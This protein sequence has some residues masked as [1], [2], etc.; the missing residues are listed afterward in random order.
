MNI[1]LFYRSVLLL[2]DGENLH[3]SRVRKLRSRRP[4]D[5]G[6]IERGGGGLT[7]AGCALFS[8]FHDT[9]GEVHMCSAVPDISE[10]EI[11]LYLL[12]LNMF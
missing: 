3:I 2:A 5:Y 6:S 9:E 8:L 12:F 10:G 4:C 11:L 1:D 7:I